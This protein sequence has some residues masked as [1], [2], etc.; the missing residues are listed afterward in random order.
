MTDP[1]LKTRLATLDDAPAIARIHNQG[2]GERIATFATEQRTAEHVANQLAAK[3]DRYPAVV[4]ELAGRVI[5]FA[6]VSVYRDTPWYSG[7][8]EHSVYVD[9]D[10]RG[11]GAGLVALDALCAACAERGYFKLVSRIFPENTASLALHERAGFRAVGTYRRHG[12]LDGE[13]RDCVIV[14]KLIGE[15]AES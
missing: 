5:A 6:W 1:V 14:E 11:R 4:V 12:K 10:Y 13:W 3:G 2:I 7:I 15:A 9:A 8:G